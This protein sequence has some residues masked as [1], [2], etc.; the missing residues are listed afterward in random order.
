MKY[1]IFS[2]LDLAQRYHQIV[3]HEKQEM[4]RL[5][6]LLIDYFDINICWSQKMHVKISR[7]CLRQTSLM[8]ITHARNPIGGSI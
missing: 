8:I 5:L 6:V 2:K 7:K 4:L 1:K 3:L